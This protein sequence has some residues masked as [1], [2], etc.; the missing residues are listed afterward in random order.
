LI[1]QTKS[2][3]GQDTYQNVSAG[4]EFSQV[5]IHIPEYQVS[6]QHDN[7]EKYQ[8]MMYSDIFL[9]HDSND[10]SNFHIVFEM[11]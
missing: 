8:N 5:V 10:C 7:K 11:L 9:C 1:L 4:I 6:S 2:Y 3:V